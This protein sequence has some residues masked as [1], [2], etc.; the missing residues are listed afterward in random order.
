M[1][2]LYS[3][4]FLFI[5]INVNSQNITCTIN[6]PTKNQIV[7]N[8]ISVK[9]TITSTLELSSVIASISGFQSN[10]IFNSTTRIF[11]GTVVTNGLKQG[12]TLELVI[13][14]KDVLNNVATSKVNV[15]YDLPPVINIL[16]PMSESVAHALLPFRIQCTD[17]DSCLLNVTYADEVIFSTKI[18]DS[19]S[20]FLNFKKFSGFYGS[21]IVDVYDSRLQKSTNSVLIYVDTSSSL[22]EYFVANS[23]IID[24]KGKKLLLQTGNELSYPEIVDISNKTQSII[25]LKIK[26]TSRSFLTPTGAILTGVD[27][28]LY[29]S[30]FSWGYDWNN[31]TINTLGSFNSAYSLVTSGN[32]ASWSN[33]T[34]L[35]LRNLVTKVNTTVSSSAI[36]WYNSVTSSGRMAFGSSSPYNIFYYRNG[37]STAV[38]TNASNKWNT[39]P[40][41]DGTNIVYR[42]HDPCCGNQTYSI[43]LTDSTGSNTTLLSDLG[44][45]EPTPPNDY[46][47]N[48]KFVAFTKIGSLGQTNVWLRDSLGVN[49]QITFFGTNADIDLLSSKGNLLFNY[50]GKRHLNLSNNNY[51]AV[52]SRLGNSYFED[53]S[54]YIA[55]GRVLFQ[56]SSN[57]SSI[58]NDTTVSY[59]SLNFCAG[60]SSELKAVSNGQYN[61]Q[62][63]KNESPIIGETKYNLNVTNSG[64]YKCKITDQNGNSIFTQTSILKQNSNPN[65][66]DILYSNS[67]L[68]TTSSATN[69]QWILNNSPIQGATSQTFSPT[70]TGLYKVQIT[71]QNGCKNIS[72]SFNLSVITAVSNNSLIPRNHIAV[73]HPNPAKYGVNVTFNSNLNSE[74]TFQIVS[75]NGQLLNQIKS[76]NKSTYLPLLGYSSG[77]YLI[78][79]IGN[80]YN[81]V[82][83]LIIQQ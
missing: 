48:N 17:I 64:N 50:N 24:F 31:N 78:K 5:G 71:D 41:T 83:Q 45:K 25:P 8:N 51:V 39:Y 49:K 72:D 38:T 29:P 53:S 6:S 3:F 46:Q 74:L 79:I 73:V 76:K 26:L 81:Q 61:Y 55:I 27:S 52:S 19:L 68:K 70:N 12:D 65:K 13:T 21:L 59:N 33:A 57:K 60:S 18:K 69:Y 62:W 15:I 1:K 67:L 63:F 30:S 44:N 2:L 14:I 37:N 20:T 56:V 23:R 42:K 77:N 10:L 28:S 22:K 58:N 47:V 11:E 4:L 9:A 32:Y 16:E 82:L 75:P 43:Y 40:I 35:Y 80:N 66:P 54:F 34:T 36:N 7:S